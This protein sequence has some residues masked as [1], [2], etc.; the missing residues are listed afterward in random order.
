M[1]EQETWTYREG[2]S[3]S[4]IWKL[5]AGWNINFY[6]SCWVRTTHEITL[7]RCGTKNIWGYKNIWPILVPRWSNWNKENGIP[8]EC[9]LW[10]GK[11]YF[12]P[13]YFKSQEVRLVEVLRL[14]SDETILNGISD[15]YLMRHW[16]NFEALLVVVDRDE[17]R[18]CEISKLERNDYSLRI[19]GLD[20]WVL[21]FVNPLH[22]NWLILW[23]WSTIR[24]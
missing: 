6:C 5:L 22:K 23:F 1:W 19:V 3:D 14:P 11:Y 10:L 15:N 7:L 2:A 16:N 24:Y 20:K 13:D 18:R 21:L 12:Q 4:D 17:L 8:C 9:W